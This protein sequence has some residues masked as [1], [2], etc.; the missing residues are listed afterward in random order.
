MIIMKRITRE[1][2]L[3]MIHLWCRL[4]V[5]WWWTIGLCIIFIFSIESF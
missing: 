1:V 5:I 4:R 2:K 3:P